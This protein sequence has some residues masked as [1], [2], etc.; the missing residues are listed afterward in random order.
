MLI[1]LSSNLSR[2]LSPPEIAAIL[3]DSISGNSSTSVLETNKFV[4]SNPNPIAL[5]LSQIL[6]K[7]FSKLVAFAV[8]KSIVSFILDTDN[9]LTTVVKLNFLLSSSYTS[10]TSVPL[11][12]D[13]L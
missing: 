12:R 9:E 1:A 3:L 10:L 11:N 5:K 2:P 13:V 8:P 4:A 6:F 7:A